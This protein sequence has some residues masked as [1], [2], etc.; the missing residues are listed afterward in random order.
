DRGHL[1]LRLFQAHAGFQPCGYR[2]DLGGA[3]IAID[4]DRV[5]W[6]PDVCLADRRKGGEGE[7]GRH[8]AYDRQCFLEEAK[9]LTERVPR[10]VALPKPMANDDCGGSVLFHFFGGEQPTKLW[11]DAEHPEELGRHKGD[12]CE[13]GFLSYYH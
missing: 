7:V 4:K 11:L 1:R 8:Y 13:L 3:T 10:E 5:G 2:I 6:N 12:N 9:S